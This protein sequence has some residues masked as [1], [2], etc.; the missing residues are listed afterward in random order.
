[1]KR[2]TLIAGGALFAVV[3]GSPTPAHGFTPTFS[4]DFQGPTI[5]TPDSF[6]IGPI[7]E[8]DVLTPATGPAP[9][10]N[11]PALGPLPPP[12]IFRTVPAIL[13]SG[14]GIRELDALSYGHDPIRNTL[15]DGIGSIYFSVDEF[16]TG[17]PGTPTPPNVATEGALGATEASADVY[18]SPAPGFLVPPPFP[19]T[20]NTLAIDGDGMVSPVPAI[21]GLGLKDPNPPTPLALPDNGDNLDALD[22]DTTPNDAGTPLYLSLDAGFGDPLEVPPANA[23]T[24]MANG[25][26]GGDVL[27]EP[28]PGAGLILYATAAALGLDKVVGAGP[29]SDDLD[30]LLVEE[31]DGILEQFAPGTDF[32]AFSVRRGSAVIGKPDSLFG[33]PIEEGDI[34]TLPVPV[35]AGGL[36]PFPSILVP[37]EWMGLATARSGTAMSLFGLQV[38]D[39]LDAL[40]ITPVPEPA[41]LALVA[42]CLV[43]MAARRRRVV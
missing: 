16:A 38:G 35:G 13:P 42:A 34:L 12:G 5:G 31:V 27:V 8:G 9:G 32:I 24:A 7:T 41:S 17:I 43:A 19:T 30:A 28:V 25:F 4:I 10:P 36:S 22:V 37:A 11:P 15:I 29:D 26:V 39:D 3:A 1:M 20:G 40:D 33:A 23:G 21:P 18:R 6:A 14:P 2:L